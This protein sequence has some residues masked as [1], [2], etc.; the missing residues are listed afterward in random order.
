MAYKSKVWEDLK[1][2]Y[3]QG[4]TTFP[5]L[6]K[7]YGITVQAIKDKSYR[8][9]WKIQRKEAIA[10][11]NQIHN[12]SMVQAFLDRKIDPAMIVDKVEKLL[13]A[14]KTVIVSSK[15]KDPETGQKEPG[16]AVEIEDFKAINDGISQYSKLTGSY[17]P[18]KHETTDKSI[19]LNSEQLK[20]NL[21]LLTAEESNWLARI[22][23]KLAQ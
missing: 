6:S 7:K 16:F 22:L 17:A 18:E 3:E 10:T 14:E 8:N 9:R 11:A 5:L 15:E 12:T 20:K 1:T 13:K 4:L 21:H 23:E 19:V 2:E